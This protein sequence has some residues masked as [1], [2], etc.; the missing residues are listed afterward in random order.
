MEV[1]VTPHSSL[2]SWDGRG[3]RQT[4]AKADGGGDKMKKRA[5]ETQ[6]G[7]ERWRESEWKRERETHTLREK[8]SA[9]YRQGI[10]RRETSHKGIWKKKKS[11]WKRPV[12]NE[13]KKSTRCLYC[14][15]VKLV[16]VK[17]WGE[18]KEGRRA[19][20]IDEKT[21]NQLCKYDCNGALGLI[22][23]KR[24]CIGVSVVTVST[25]AWSQNHTNTLL[26]RS[27]W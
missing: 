21:G 19:S 10:L 8:L 18:K 24:A 23:L 13:Q 5:R 25:E 6:K 22:Y 27:K 14:I 1:R 16:A 9:V 12:K 7:K 3:A 15:D 2:S 20:F 11:E 26:I 17:K 4:K